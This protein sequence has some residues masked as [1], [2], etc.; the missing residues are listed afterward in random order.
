MECKGCT[1]GVKMCFHR[2]C[3]G[4]PE[5]FERIIDAGFADK[6]RI[7]Y[8]AGR[9][10]ITEE[11]LDMLPEFIKKKYLEIENPYTEDI[12]MLTGGTSDD[13]D[14]RAP[15]WLIPG[16]ACKFLKDDLCTLHDLGLKPEQGR[17]SCCDKEICQA[18]GN[19]D[20]AHLWVTEKG[21]EVVQ[22]FKTLMK[23]DE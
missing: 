8:W 3:F 5:E 13:R 17:D 1:R 4:T 2:P 14:F 16:F 19:L 9:K 15:W 12:E 6:L 22:K 11:Q 18:K 20:Y 7:D 23:L 10:P 21:K